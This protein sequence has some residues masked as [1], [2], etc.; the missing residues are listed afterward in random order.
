[1]IRPALLYGCETWPMS[2]KDEKRMA[3]TLERYTNEA[4]V[5]EPKGEQI[6][7]V[8]RRRRLEW[9]EYVKRRDETENIR[10]VVEMKMAGKRPRGR[11]KLRWKDTVRRDMKAWKIMEEWNFGVSVRPATLHKETAAKE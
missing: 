5:A 3:T 1:M 4:I 7:M 10:A 8:M 9:F 11:P 2:A 6:A